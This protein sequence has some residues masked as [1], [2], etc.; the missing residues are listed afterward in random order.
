[1]EKDIE[2]LIEYFERNLAELLREHQLDPNDEFLKGKIAGIK[3]A[4]I[5]C[6]MYNRPENGNPIDVIID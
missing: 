3:Q 5:T 6:R 2:G 1:M 4:L